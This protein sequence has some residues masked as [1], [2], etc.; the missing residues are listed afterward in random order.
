MKQSRVPF[1]RMIF[2]CTNVRDTGESACANAERGKNSGFE[3]VKLLRDEAKKR[4]LKGKIRIAKSG[5]MDLCAAGPNVMIFD[6]KGDYTWY[7]NVSTDDIPDLVEK[8]I[9]VIS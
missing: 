9:S 7:S 6:E 4:G 1:R 3:L 2:V 5:C 8:Y